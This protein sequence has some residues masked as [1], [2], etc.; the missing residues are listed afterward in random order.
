M[1]DCVLVG[2]NAVVLSHASI[3][4]RT[5]VGA[6]ALVSEHKQFP[7]GVMVMGVPAKIVRE[8]SEVE[9]EGLA[10]SAAGYCERAREH[11]KSLEAME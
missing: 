9:T 4:A 1:G 10:K 2:I 11:K 6:C 5:L 8:L 3:G 7:E